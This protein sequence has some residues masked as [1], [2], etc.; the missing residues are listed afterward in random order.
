[1]RGSG[2]RPLEKD[3]PPSGH[4]ASGLP[5]F[6]A[7]LGVRADRLRGIV[8]RWRSA[9][10]VATGQVG[11][12]PAWC[13]LTR[14]GLAVTGQ[15][16]TTARPAAARLAHLR[17][18]LAVR[19][20]LEASPAYRDGRAW[21][22]SERR[23]RA[24]IGGR[25]SGHVPDAEVSWPDVPAS[26]YSGQCWAI[27]AE[28]TPKP[29]ARTASI[30]AGLL[31]RAADYYPGS[32]RGT[33]PRYDRVVYLAAPAARGVT[34][35]AAA[36]LPARLRARITVRDLPPGRACEHRVGVL[37][38]PGDRLAAAHGRAPAAARRRAGGSGSRRPGHPGDRCGG[39]WGVVAR[40]A[41]D[42]VAPR[43]KV[44][45]ADDRGVPD[46]AGG[47]GPHLAGARLSPGP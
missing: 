33:R 45:A 8:A 29:L 31:A 28:L 10:Y 34:D 42:P 41:A 32:A 39:G 38:V 14:A 21:W 12:G 18:V 35:R 2:R 24:A 43:G 22:R 1:M 19:M 25:A 9:G 26:P 17:A 3:P 46:W 4:L 7:F 11:A 47:A 16:Y 40:V 13:W 5:E 36:T 6:A 15:P 20:S 37:A 30:M 44:G 23:I 27:E